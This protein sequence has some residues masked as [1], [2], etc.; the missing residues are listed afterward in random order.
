MS[1]KVDRE[2]MIE[3]SDSSKSTSPI[4]RNSNHE[5]AWSAFWW[6]GSLLVI[7]AIIAIGLV[8]GTGGSNSGFHTTLAIQEHIANQTNQINDTA[9]NLSSA[10]EQ[11]LSTSLSTDKSTDSTVKAAEGRVT[12]FFIGYYA[13]G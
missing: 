9:Q 1:E 3:M 8:V 5:S 2:K 6:S 13:F 12:N 7:G 10:A 11:N 4:I